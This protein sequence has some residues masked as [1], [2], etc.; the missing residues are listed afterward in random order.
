MCLICLTTEV[1]VIACWTNYHWNLSRPQNQCVEFSLMTTA[2]IS[3]CHDDIMTWK[4]FLHYWL[5]LRETINHYWIPLTKQSYWPG[6]KRASDSD[7]KWLTFPCGI[8][9][10]AVLLYFVLLYWLV[11]N[12]KIRCYTCIIKVNRFIFP[13]ACAIQSIPFIIQHSPMDS[14]QKPQTS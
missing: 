14:Q 9:E 1:N 8:G 3:L 2:I 12:S 11:T 4:Y 6:S 7:P 10:I 13:C 5:F